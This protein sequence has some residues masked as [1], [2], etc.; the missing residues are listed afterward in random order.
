MNKV[1]AVVVM[2]L[3][4]VS[5]EAAVRLTFH[6]GSDTVWNDYYVRGAAYCTRFSFGEQCF[7]RE[8]VKSI[9]PVSEPDRAEGSVGVSLGGVIVDE[10]ASAINQAAINE[11]SRHARQRDMED[12]QASRKKMLDEKYGAHPRK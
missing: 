6:D 3:V 1:L 10:Q 5:A 12:Q 4:A 9:S 2:L 11:M 7:S 8:Q